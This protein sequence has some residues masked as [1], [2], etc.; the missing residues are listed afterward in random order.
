MYKQSGESED[1]EVTGEGIGEWEME[2][3]VPEWGWRRGR[4]KGDI[5]LTLI[6][7]GVDGVEDCVHAVLTVRPSVYLFVSTQF[8]VLPRRLKM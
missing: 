4:P 7:A 2:E 8:D 3:R 1:E 6:V 5:A